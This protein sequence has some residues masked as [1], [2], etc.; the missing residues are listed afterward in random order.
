MI[1]AEENEGTGTWIYRFG[2]ASTAAKSVSLEV[3][4]SATPEA[5]QYK[6]T[7]TWELSAVPNND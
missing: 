4:Q 2:D 7:L 3:P 5:T 1:R 6:T